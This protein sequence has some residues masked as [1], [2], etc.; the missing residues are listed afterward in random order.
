[1]T[2]S[3]KFQARQGDVFIRAAAIPVDAKPVK[4]EGGRVVLAFGEVTG[5][6]HA[7]YSGRVAM[8]RDDGAGRTF[9][10]IPADARDTAPIFG[11]DGVTVAGAVEIEGAAL[12]HEEHTTIPVP[13]GDYEVIRQ[14]EYSPEE[15]RQVAD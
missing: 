5:H 7:F 3:K 4:P 6:A 8:F 14:R 10:R 13:P 9:I 11:E 12:R 1:M 15:I 2:T